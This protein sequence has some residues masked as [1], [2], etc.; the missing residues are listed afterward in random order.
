MVGTTMEGRVDS[1]ERDVG[2]MKGD[3]T[4]LKGE[5]RE[6]KK[7]VNSLKEWV[8][9]I[10]DSLAKLEKKTTDENEQDRSEGFGADRGG[11]NREQHVDESNE[12]ERLR[13]V[14]GGGS[15]YGREGI[16][17]AQQL[18]TR[19]T[20]QTWGG[21]VVE[22]R[23]KLELISAPLKDASEEMLIGAYQKGLKED[24]QAELRMDKASKAVKV[25]HS[26]KWT[27]TRPNFSKPTAQI[28]SS[29]KM[30]NTTNVSRNIESKVST[31]KQVASSTS[32]TAHPQMQEQE[33]PCPYLVGSIRRG[34]RDQIGEEDE[35]QHEG[36]EL[37]GSLMSLSMNSILGITRGRTMKLV[38]KVK[39]EEVLV[40][41]DSRAS[42]NFICTSLVDKMSLPKVKT[43]SYMV[44]VRDGHS[45][46]SE[47]RCK[48][49][50][51]EL[52]G[53]TLT[54]DF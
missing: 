47:G 3:I 7:D 25:F 26:T 22:Y 24:I 6:I 8:L 2:K 10:K 29:A 32:S 30:K 37:A 4:I 51:V 31:G 53:T 44:R 27:T 33:S 49:L 43:S 52:Q 21:S 46:K 39:G 13:E 5:V 12:K 11:R 18:E 40:T 28:E 50:R 35:S 15:V 1:V 38:G 23:E 54:Q 9:E 20:I 17:L 16:E 14:G 19:M 48:K 42:H 45:V 41:I 36:E 34:R